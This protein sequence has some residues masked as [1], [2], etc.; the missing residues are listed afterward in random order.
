MSEKKDSFRYG[1]IF[2][3]MELLC[4][5]SGCIILEDCYN[6]AVLRWGWF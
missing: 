2:C 3:V 5:G 6:E 4:K 1:Y